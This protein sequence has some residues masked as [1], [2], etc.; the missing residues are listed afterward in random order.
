MK[1]PPGSWLM[2]A[3]KV[4]DTLLMRGGP[5]EDGFIRFAYRPFDTRWLYWEG[6]TQSL[7]NDKR[8]R[9]QDRI[10]FEG[11]LWLII[12]RNHLRDLVT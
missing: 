6:K 4:R 12:R 11:N 8:T 5:N 9:L 2:L 1:R 10:C 7:L 3:R